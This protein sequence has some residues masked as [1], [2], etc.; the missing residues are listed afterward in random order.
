MVSRET[1]IKMGNFKSA[2]YG[3]MDIDCK[4]IAII[5]DIMPRGSSRCPQVS[6]GGIWNKNLHLYHYRV[7]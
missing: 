6:A 7:K 1:Q 2:L 4:N 5:M 3:N